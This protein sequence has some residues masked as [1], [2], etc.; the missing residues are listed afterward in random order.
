[1]ER[2]DFYE[3]QGKAVHL[4]GMKLGGALVLSIGTRWM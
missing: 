2:T 1:M 3:G 4:H